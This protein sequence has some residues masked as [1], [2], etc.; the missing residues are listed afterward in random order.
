MVK[1]NSN[2]GFKFNFK[3]GAIF[4]NVN[5]KI[6]DLNSKLDS[7]KFPLM[8]SKRVYAI[9]VELLYNTIY[10]GV[11]SA[12]GNPDIEY[13]VS[14]TPE[15]VIIKSSNYILHKEVEAF[16]DIVCDLNQLSFDDLRK[17][18]SHQIKNG[19]IT[20]KGGAG[21][22]LIDICMK[23]DLPVEIN[24]KTIDKDLDWLTLEVKIN[25]I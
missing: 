12:D 8:V 20:P 19:G 16:R 6:I 4:E 14:A 10:H 23:S 5:N 3:G 22:G 9:T 11:E 7:S 15:N 24:F 21:L 25:L 13:S 18:K 2:T 1:V 17:K